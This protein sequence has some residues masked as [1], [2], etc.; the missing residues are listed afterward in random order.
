MSGHSGQRGER[1]GIEEVVDQLFRLRIVADWPFKF[2]D[3]PFRILWV[4]DQRLMNSIRVQSR[5]QVGS[6]VASRFPT[7]P[8]DPARQLVQIQFLGEVVG[9]SET[10]LPR[11][12][13][14]QLGRFI[15]F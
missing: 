7:Q 4:V 11:Q 10:E 9:M 8:R 13:I 15:P 5:S 1:V 14:Q 6:S 3:T 12:F 2:Q